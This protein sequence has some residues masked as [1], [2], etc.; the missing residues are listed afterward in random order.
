LGGGGGGGFE[1]LHW[2]DTYQFNVKRQNLI[3]DSAPEPVGNQSQCE[4]CPTSYACKLNDISNAICK[5]RGIYLTYQ[6]AICL[7]EMSFLPS[8]YLSYKCWFGLM[9]IPDSLNQIPAD[10]LA[11]IW[12]GK[13]C[14]QP[15]LISRLLSTQS[16]DLLFSFVQISNLLCHTTHTEA[17][18]YNSHWWMHMRYSAAWWGERWKPQLQ[19]YGKMHIGEN[20]YLS[21][22]I[23]MRQNPPRIDWPEW[24]AI[25]M[26]E[27]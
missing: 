20:K 9:K 7:T 14:Q 4:L 12:I 15:H 26:C 21:R 17:T 1:W 13:L 11:D 16:L 24:G 3:S 8:I 10:L 6:M 2:C 23:P 5:Y 25:G 22:S 27:G 19:L 18:S